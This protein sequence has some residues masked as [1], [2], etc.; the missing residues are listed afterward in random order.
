MES[1]W[2]KP[3]RSR[4]ESWIDPIVPCRVAPFFFARA[5]A[6]IA[7]RSHGGIPGGFDSLPRA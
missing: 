5:F 7:A 4:F 1:S 6:G 3:N 2:L